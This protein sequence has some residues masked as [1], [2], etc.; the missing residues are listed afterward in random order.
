L[1]E[2]GCLAQLRGE[3]CDLDVLT[4]MLKVVDKR[5]LLHHCFQAL[6]DQ[7]LSD[8]RTKIATLLSQ[9][10]VHRC[11]QADINDQQVVDTL[12]VQGLAVSTFLAEAGWLPD[13]EI[14]LT[15][16]QDLLADSENPQQLTRA[17]ECCH[18]LLHVQNGY[19][20]FEEAER[21]YNQAMQLVKRLQQE[22]ITP[23]LSSLY[24]EFSTLYMLRSNYAEASFSSFL[25]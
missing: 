20:R 15:S 25:N 13:A 23:N 6:M 11:S 19:C 22:G 17:L 1:Y 3:L 5:H 21:T 24:S 7:A 2:Y 8:H 16:C 18:R 9:A 4:R 10:Y 12:V 14:I